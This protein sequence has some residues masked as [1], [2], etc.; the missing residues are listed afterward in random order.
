MIKPALELVRH[1]CDLVESEVAKRECPRKARK[2]KQWSI[3]V[4]AVRPCIVL[5]SWLPLHT[6]ISELIVKD[7]SQSGNI[8]H[9]SRHVFGV[10]VGFDDGLYM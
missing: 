1:Q 5:S 4:R 9:R 10:G 2:Q 7:V 6:G 3:V 8:D